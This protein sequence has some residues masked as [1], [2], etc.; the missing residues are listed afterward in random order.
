MDMMLELE[1]SKVMVLMGKLES[2]WSDAL[3]LQQQRG[4]K[5]LNW[6]DLANFSAGDHPPHLVFFE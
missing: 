3:Y 1:S 5:A 2:R 6:R 4:W